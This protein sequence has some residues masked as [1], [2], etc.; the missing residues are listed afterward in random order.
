MTR[1]LLGY[2][3]DASGTADE[4]L[5]IYE[6]VIN[7]R[8]T[9][10]YD[11]SS[12]PAMPVALI[13][14]GVHAGQEKAAVWSVYQMVKAMFASEASDC[15]L[16]IMANVE[17]RIV[18]IVNPWAYNT[19]ARTNARGVNINRNFSVGWENANQDAASTE[20]RGPA[21]YSEL[22]TQAIRKWMIDHSDA[23]LLI[24]CH[25]CFA[26]NEYA[27]GQ[28]FDSASRNTYTTYTRRMSEYLAR[29][30]GLNSGKNFYRDAG[31]NFTPVLALEAGVIG[32]ARHAL[33]ESN[34]YGLADR[35]MYGRQAIQLGV[36]AL[37][38]FLLAMLNA[39]A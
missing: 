2:G 27:Y 36:D 28:S 10:L 30:Y 33:I 9:A 11:G 1:N 22:E 15:L 12:I 17:L 4:S 6:Y 35:V 34:A 37:V 8:S 20:Y 38:N 7:S 18:P 29:R 24:D 32:I 26:E 21:I 14:S 3:S 23:L 5:P 13:A 25:N 39:E 19:G 31:G 16:D